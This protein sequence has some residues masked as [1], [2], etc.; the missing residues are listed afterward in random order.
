MVSRLVVGAR[1]RLFALG[2][3]TCAGAMGC[4]PG[5]GFPTA[6]ILPS[7]TAQDWPDAS[8]AVLEDIATLEF[9]SMAVDG[10]K[11]PRVVAVLDHRRRTKILTSAGLEHAQV[12]LPID[13]Y[14]TITRVIARSVDP[15]GN[16]T[17]MAS[18]A[19][20]AV[21]R[22]DASERAP[23]VKILRFTIPAAAVGGLLEYRYERV[24]V[25]PLLLPPWVFGDDVPV[26]HSELGIVLDPSIKIDYRFGRGDTLSDRGALKR[27]L[28][29]GRERLVFIETDLPPFYSEP[30]MPNIA[31]TAPWLAVAVRAGQGSL[32]PYV[33][34]WDQVA[35]VITERMIKVGGKPHAGTMQERFR[36]VRD[37]IKPL[38]LP[39]LGVRPPVDA[40]DLTQGAPAC[41][42]DGVALLMGALSGT[43]ATVYPALLA[44]PGSPPVVED[45]PAL[46]PFVRAAAAVEV[47]ESMLRDPACTGEPMKR[48]AWCSAPPGSFILLDP[49][50]KECR[51][52][53]LESDLTGGRALVLAPHN[54][55]WI[56]VPLD[57][58]DRN[59][60]KVDYRLQLDVEGNVTGSVDGDARGVPARSL[61]RA[62]RDGDSDVALKNALV[63]ENDAVTVQDTKFG[64]LT[65]VDQPLHL[66]ANLRSH[67]QRQDYERFRLR[68]VDL[69]GTGMPG[70]WRSSRR[71][72]AVLDGPRWSETT[73]VI[74]LPVGFEVENKPAVKLSTPFAEYAAGFAQRGRALHYSRRVVLKTHV[75]QPQQ[76][77]DFFQFIEQI[78]VIE[79]DGPNV[80]TVD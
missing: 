50:C 56:D 79:A 19:I 41:S 65:E 53:E 31:H 4:T 69:V 47:S 9:R 34:T 68:P 11:T 32:G 40:A 42:R 28:P 66:H 27:T 13:G 55:R 67:A 76:W 3:L 24:Y 6:V 60:L 78:R 16:I 36:S 15:S 57:N 46:Y 48:G 75:I 30:H 17:T 58:P 44:A 14:S 52:G 70:A 12:E 37:A 49:L 38:T 26:L 62:A 18:S 71:Y 74:Q 7:P 10:S 72:P 45:F 22:S 29:D 61:R 21:G 64:A 20:E 59:M 63:G 51:F 33:S 54:A 23:E 43:D 39:G 2:L 5:F 77:N 25:D 73:A 8:V 35:D 80:F 1:V